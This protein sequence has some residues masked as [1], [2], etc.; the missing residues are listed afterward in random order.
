MH[1]EY[2]DGAPLT[3]T[4]LFGMTQAVMFAQVLKSAGEDLTR[5]SL[6]DAL[7]TQEWRG[8][9]LV[10]FSSSGDDHGGHQGV[11]VTQ[12]SEGDEIELVQGARVT[13]RSGGSVEEIDFERLS[14]EELD[15]HD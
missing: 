2:G 14:P 3:N 6:I 11:Y 4:H 5:Q 8:P 15:F 10:P 9:G 7:E 1:E 12:Y 13:D